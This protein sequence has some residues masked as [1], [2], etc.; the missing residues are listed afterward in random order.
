MLTMWIILRRLGNSR[1]ALIIMLCISA[2][3]LNWELQQPNAFIVLVFFCDAVR[4]KKL[5]SFLMAWKDF[6]EVQIESVPLWLVEPG[7]KYSARENA[8]A[9]QYHSRSKLVFFT[10]A[11]QRHSNPVQCIKDDLRGTGLTCTSTTR[12]KMGWFQTYKGQTRP[13]I[14][15]IVC[16]MIY[17]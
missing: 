5:I 3:C 11:E 2:V 15:V 17:L 7:Q 13:S 9:L 12:H 6:I 8:L 14:K 10:E 1:H 4:K 16:A